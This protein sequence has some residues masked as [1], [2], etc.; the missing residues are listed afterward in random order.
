MNPP[1]EEALAALALTKPGMHLA[2][3]LDATCRALAQVAGSR[4]PGFRIES[5]LP[6]PPSAL[7]LAA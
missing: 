7:S 2:A 1:R 4:A 5:P 3:F 6:S